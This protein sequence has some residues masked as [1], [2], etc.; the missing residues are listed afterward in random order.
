MTAPDPVRLAV[1]AMGTRFEMVLHDGDPVRLRAAGEEALEEILR[2]ERQLSVFQPASEIFH[3]NSQAALRPVKVSPSLF[4]LLQK[5]V[6]IS[7]ETRGAFDITVA[8]LVQCWGFMGG[9]AAVPDEPSLAMARSAVGWDGLKFDESDWTVAFRRPAMMLDLGAIGK[10][11]AL[12]QAVGILREAG[13]HSALLHGGTSSVYGLGA[14]PDA[15][16][17]KIALPNPARFARGDQTS[18]AFL[19]TLLLQDMA[20]SVSAIWGRTITAGAKQYGHVIDPRTGHPVEDAVM[21][22]AV[23]PSNTEADAFST[24]LL[25]GG[26]DDFAKLA[27]LRPDLKCALV[28][29]EKD[30]FSFKTRGIEIRRDAESEVVWPPLL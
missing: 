20:L 7:R 2:L 30:G 15:A 1:N 3:L 16:P 21:A 8:P 28:L 22:A 26:A 23:L 9:S 27:G 4:A 6:S 10:G 24:A 29:E 14:Q 12:D 19:G 5:A 17:W 25:T 11:Y 13:I 18:S